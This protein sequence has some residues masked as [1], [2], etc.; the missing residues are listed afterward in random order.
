MR[1]IL[2][3]VLVLGT[4]LVPAQAQ[5][6]ATPVP[7]IAPIVITNCELTERR[8]L[9]PAKGLTITWVNKRQ[10]PL[11]TIDFEVKYGGETQRVT[12]MG[13]YTH[14][15]VITKSFSLFRDFQFVGSKPDSC[16]VAQAIY[17]DETSVVP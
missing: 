13:T 15:A 10:I 3:T 4:M 2:L 11:K 7:W 14:G 8:G 5:V 9:V 17:A 12:D 16:R 6:A 1:R